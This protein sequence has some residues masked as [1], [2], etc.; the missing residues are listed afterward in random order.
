MIFDNNRARFDQGF[1]IPL[2]FGQARIHGMHGRIYDRTVGANSNAIANLNQFS[3]TDRPATHAKILSNLD[4][5]ARTHCTKNNTM[6]QSHRI[7]ISIRHQ[8]RSL[9]YADSRSFHHVDDRR[10]NKMHARPYGK[11]LVSPSQISIYSPTF[12]CPFYL[13]PIPRTRFYLEKYF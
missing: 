9:P 12:D 8:G 7:K 5:C 10:S 3:R 6:G 13:P 2:L 1:I 4:V 11:V